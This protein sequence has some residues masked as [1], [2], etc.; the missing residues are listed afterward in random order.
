[1]SA[2]LAAIVAINNLATQ[3]IVWLRGELEIAL[4]MAVRVALWFYAYDFVG[5]WNRGKHPNS[6]RDD[7]LTSLVF[8]HNL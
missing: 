6:V 4:N 2:F 1:M 3:E 7:P 8:L 5:Q